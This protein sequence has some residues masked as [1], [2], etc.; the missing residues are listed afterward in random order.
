MRKASA[1][2]SLY[3]HFGG[4]SFTLV[5]HDII[6][7]ALECYGRDDRSE[8]VIRALDLPRPAAWDLLAEE[9][10]VA[11]DEEEDERE[12]EDDD[13]GAGDGTSG[14]PGGAPYPDTEPEDDEPD[15]ESP[16]KRPKRAMTPSPAL[17]RELAAFAAWRVIPMNR[18]RAAAA[19]TPATVQGNRDCILRLMGWLDAQGKL[20]SSPTLACFAS[21]QMS[22]AA[23]QFAAMLTAEGLSYKTIANHLGAFLATARYAATRCSTA[24]PSTITELEHL[25]KS[26]KKQARVQQ[27]FKAAKDQTVTISWHDVL[28]ARVNAEAAFNAYTGGSLTK[29]IALT[30]D[31][32]VLRLHSDS[33][34]DRVRVIRELKLG[35]TLKKTAGGYDL[36]LREEGLHKTSAVMGPSLTALPT[37]V[38]PW[39]ELWI[40]LTSVPADGLLFAS[41]G[42]DAITPPN[43][44]RMVRACFKRYA[45]VAVTP[46]D[47]R[48]SYITYLKS[49]QHSDESLR[50]AAIAMRHNTA[51]QSSTAYHKRNTLA[52]SAVT[53]AANLS[54]QYM[55]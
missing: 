19:A 49:D 28:Q 29:K 10:I 36:D 13:D 2:A 27:L 52:Q 39:L 32:L 35:S 9:E 47:L 24:S 43:W 11:E 4:Q 12:E 17:E 40:K 25:H 30:R 1:R 50:A 33:P 14:A 6:P 20:P 26:A 5:P 48:S 42:G 8:A 45:G 15:A 7:M 18:E 53:E 16:S 21:N 3:S 34:P 51:T 31:V 55:H 54:A 44:G 22:K 46:K 41:R 38:V 37:S 23:Q